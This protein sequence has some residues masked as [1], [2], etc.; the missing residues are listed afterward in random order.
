MNKLIEA[1]IQL[2]NDL[3][4]VFTLNNL[5]FLLLSMIFS[6]INVLNL[7]LYILVDHIQDRLNEINVKVVKRWH[8]TN[9]I[10]I[11][12]YISNTPPNL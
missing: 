10:A 11:V 2:N 8:H 4:E 1:F 3:N 5:K 9:S 6:Q 12:S 7:N